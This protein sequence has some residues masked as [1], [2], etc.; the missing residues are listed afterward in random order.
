MFP[1]WMASIIPQIGTDIEG[2]TSMRAIESGFS[3]PSIT[4]LILL[5]LAAALAPQPLI[6][7]QVDQGT[8]TDVTFTETLPK[9]YGQAKVTA[10]LDAKKEKL[11]RLDVLF[12]G[13]R[14]Y[15]PQK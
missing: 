2:A 15:V 1:F 11:E 6:A 8:R 3:R 9:P 10:R 13:K 7:S 5:G 14:V 12:G 4:V